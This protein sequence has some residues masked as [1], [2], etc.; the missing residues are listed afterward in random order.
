M[1]MPFLE[2]SCIYIKRKDI[3]KIFVI[4]FDSLGIFYGLNIH[5]YIYN[6]YIYIYNFLKLIVELMLT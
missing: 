2:M 3:H 4:N 5:I 1:C 6:I